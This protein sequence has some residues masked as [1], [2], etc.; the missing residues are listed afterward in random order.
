[1]IRGTKIGILVLILTLMLSLTACDK[2]LLW[3]GSNIGSNLH[4]SY[5]LFTGNEVKK[6]KAKSG[7]TIIIDYQSKVE[8]GDLSIKL[9]DPDDTLIKE[10]ATNE[11]G[12]EE[13]KADKDG[14]YKIKIV[15][16]KTTGNFKVDYKIE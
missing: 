5:K 7:E 15:G 12:V 1:M 9:Y 3:V 6:I 8:K 13:I 10:F 2:S 4:A 16:E 11:A 14:K